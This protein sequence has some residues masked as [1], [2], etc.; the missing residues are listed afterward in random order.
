MLYDPAI[1][2]EQVGLA[3]VTLGNY[4]ASN[5]TSLVR[6]TDFIVKRYFGPDRWPRRKLWITERG[7]HR[8]ATRDYRVNHDAPRLSRKRHYTRDDTLPSLEH[9]ASQSKQARK[10]GL[11]QAIA[12][13]I[14]M[15]IANPC[16]S[17]DCTCKLH[18]YI[19]KSDV[20]AYLLSD[21]PSTWNPKTR[22]HDPA[23]LP[24]PPRPK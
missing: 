11:R 7:L 10:L 1:V 9:L 22:K 19:P 13:A 12:V 14:E 4:C 23:P 24:I 18:K 2:C 16:S 5:R 20:L 6:G 3:R 8:L 15:A 17:P 21:A